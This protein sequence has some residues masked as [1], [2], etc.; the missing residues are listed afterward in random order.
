M[1]CRLS[2]RARWHGRARNSFAMP[3]RANQTWTNTRKI[4]RFNCH[5]VL[6]QSCCTE[7]KLLSLLS[8]HDA[9]V[10]YLHCPMRHSR[11]ANFFCLTRRLLKSRF[12]LS[13]LTLRLQ[14][15]TLPLPPVL[16]LVMFLAHKHVILCP[17]LYDPT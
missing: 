1:G 12:I 7:G 4:S 6:S 17:L 2:Q 10:T 14:A 5:W 15:E 3:T 11:M 8:P 13:M 16:V 9:F